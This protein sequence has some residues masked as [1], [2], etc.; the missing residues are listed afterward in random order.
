M[1]ITTHRN[2]RNNRFMKNRDLKAGSTRLPFP[3]LHQIRLRTSC[4]STRSRRRRLKQSTTRQLLLSHRNPAHPSLASRRR[5]TCLTSKTRKRLHPTRS[6]RLKRKNIPRRQR[7]RLPSLMR[8][9]QDRRSKNQKR[10]RSDI[11]TGPIIL[12]NSASPRFW[13]R[14]RMGRVRCWPWSM[15]S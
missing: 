3:M 1:R 8:S 13:S 14:T 12:A 7:N 10:T 5:L 2:Q 15:D 6:V 4:S 9:W 11:S